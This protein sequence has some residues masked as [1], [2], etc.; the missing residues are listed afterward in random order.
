MIAALDGSTVVDGRS[1]ALGNETDAAV[2]RQMR[3]IADVILVGARTA[4][5]ETYGPPRKA[6][7]R[8]GVVTASGRVELDRPLFTSGAGFVVTTEETPIGD[9][10]ASVPD[11]VRAGVDG[12]DL[13]RAISAVDEL[14]ERPETILFEG[15]PTLNGALLDADVIDEWD[16]TTSSRAVG[17]DGPRLASGARDTMRPFALTQL[18]VDDDGFLY[19]RW[20]RNREL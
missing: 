6:A 3:E 10:D 5:D 12:V 17:G 1:G 9:P 7:Q 18:G 8:V 2:L 19:A 4:R 15:G 13:V 14:C 11:I 16:I 20:R